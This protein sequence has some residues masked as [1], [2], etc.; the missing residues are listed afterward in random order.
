M[1]AGAGRRVERP[2]SLSGRVSV[3]NVQAMTSSWR[4]ERRPHWA[5][6]RRGRRSTP[7]WAGSDKG[8]EHDGRSNSVLPSWFPWRRSL[9]IWP[10]ARRPLESR[11]TWA[12]FRKT[13]A[14]VLAFAVRRVASRIPVVRG[15]GDGLVVTRYGGKVTMGRAIGASTASVIN[16][17]NDRVVGMLHVGPKPH[18]LADVG[19]TV[20]TRRAPR[21]ARTRRSSSRL[22]AKPHATNCVPVARAYNGRLFRAGAAGRWTSA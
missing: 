3:E 7:V 1:I 19:G 15:P 8:E 16:A 4:R 20:V 6:Q 10:T 13:L 22:R 2:R 21:W 11:S 17:A 12:S 9:L 14:A 18:G 5:R